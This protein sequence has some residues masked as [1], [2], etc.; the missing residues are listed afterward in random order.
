MGNKQTA[1]MGKVQISTSKMSLKI[2]LWLAVVALL[3]IPLVGA[4][5]VDTDN[6][7]QDMWG[8][9]CVTYTSHPSM[10]RAYDTDVFK[11][12]EMCCACGGGVREPTSMPSN[13]PTAY[14]QGPISTTCYDL[15]SSYQNHSCCS[16]DMGKVAT[17]NGTAVTCGNVL[18]SYKSSECCDADLAKNATMI[19]N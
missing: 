12:H 14:V 7:A 11:S 2:C 5:C 16:Q 9:P 17:F 13:E 1:E 4:N 15:K 19:F 18:A 8:N 6:G 3:A 10:C